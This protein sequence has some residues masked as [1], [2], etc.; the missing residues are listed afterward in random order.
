MLKETA[1]TV[2]EPTPSVS[3]DRVGNLEVSFSNSIIILRENCTLNAIE[4]FQD[5]DVLMKAA[6]KLNKYRSGEGGELL[7]EHMLAGIPEV[8]LGIK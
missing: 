1:E 8:D 3:H 4:F 5:T 7:S 2:N 6:S